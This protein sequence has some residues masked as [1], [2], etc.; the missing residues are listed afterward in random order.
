MNVRFVPY[1]NLYNTLS[2]VV[3]IADPDL[4]IGGKK[5]EFNPSY[6]RGNMMVLDVTT[7]DGALAIART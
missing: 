5:E 2:D 6:L 4:R 7:M 3:V 1:Q